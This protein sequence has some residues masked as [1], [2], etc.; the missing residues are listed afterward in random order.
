MAAV[1]VVRA[2]RYA[3]LNQTYNA[4]CNSV[5]TDLTQDVFT[6]DLTSGHTFHGIGPLVSLEA[7]WPIGE[8]GLALLASGRGALLLGTGHQYANM[9]FSDVDQYGD[10]VSQSVTSQAQSGGGT[11]PMCSSSKS[12]PNGEDPSAARTSLFKQAWSARHGSRRA[13][14]PTSR[15]FSLPACR[16]I[17]PS[18]KRPWE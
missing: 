6:T 11:L 8:T 7:K 14:P 5:P 4:T 12:A 2:A 3:Q 1:I 13:T 18:I 15:A 9:N 10:L 17:A 16:P